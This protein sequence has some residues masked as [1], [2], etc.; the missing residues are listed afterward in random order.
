MIDLSEKYWKQEKYEESLNLL[1]RSV[2]MLEV[3]LRSIAIENHRKTGYQK[4]L[5]MAILLERREN[6][7]K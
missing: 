3:E 6:F 2:C 1:R 4:L 7:F 5:I